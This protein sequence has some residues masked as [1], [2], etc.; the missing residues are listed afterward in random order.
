MNPHL[1]ALLAQD[2]NIFDHLPVILECE[3][4]LIDTPRGPV[5]DGRTAVTLINDT[6]DTSVSVI[7]PNEDLPALQDAI[8]THLK[9]ITQ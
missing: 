4:M 6:T 3:H 8:T 7:V 5:L 2:P 9:E 1:A